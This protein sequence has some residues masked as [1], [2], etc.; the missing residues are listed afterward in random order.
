MPI[1]SGLNKNE[2]KIYD[3]Y[4]EA[5]KKICSLEKEVKHLKNEREKFCKHIE[6]TATEIIDV[7]RLGPDHVIPNRVVYCGSV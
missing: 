3:A 1:N 5:L 7:I 6:K 4:N 2:N